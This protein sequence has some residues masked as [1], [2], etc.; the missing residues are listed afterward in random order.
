[1]SVYAIAGLA[2]IG[3]GVYLLLVPKLIIGAI[4]CIIAGLIVI[5]GGLRA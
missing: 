1:M 5:G 3:V 4:I 2:L